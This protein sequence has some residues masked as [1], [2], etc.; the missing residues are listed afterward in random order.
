[1][2]FYELSYSNIRSKINT[3]GKYMTNI[4]HLTETQA[5][6]EMGTSC[7]CPAQ[8]VMSQCSPAESG[9]GSQLL[10]GFTVEQRAP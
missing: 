3:N 6:T 9:F 7:R 2:G 8:T 1:M 5:M 10:T 4:C